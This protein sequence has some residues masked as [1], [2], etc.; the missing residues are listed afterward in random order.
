[1]EVD[2]GQP[3][4]VEDARCLKQTLRELFRNTPLGPVSLLNIRCAPGL[5]FRV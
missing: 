3:L 4:S 1:M 2:R 5:G